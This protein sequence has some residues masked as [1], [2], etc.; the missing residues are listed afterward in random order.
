MLEVLFLGT[1]ASLPSRDRSPPCIA[2]RSNSDIVLLDCGEGSQRQMMISPM[3]FMKI[4]GIFITHM[5]GDHVFGLPGLLQTMGMSGRKDPLIVCGP[6]GFKDALAA[7]IH[8]CPGEILYALD[9]RELRDGDV[10]DMGS[11]E[12]YC[13][14]TMHNMPSLGY[15]LKEKDQKGRFDKEKAVKLGL[16]PSDYSRLQEGQS[17]EG[18]TPDM[19]I[20]PSRPGLRLVYSGDTL[21]CDRVREVSSDADLLIHEA[22]YCENETDL[23]S[24]YFHTTAKQAAEIA[25]DSRCKNLILVHI[26]N[27]YDDRS[28]VETEARGTFP[29]SYVADDLQM[30]MLTKEGLRSV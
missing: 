17:V 25:R 22:T 14:E 12:V 19:V 8:F 9:I 28:I 7:M 15:S 18:V 1:G 6:E 2:V 20:G 30:Y 21:P 13:F 10:V 5:H 27:R 29:S 3:S 24:K 11:T 16:R 23:A 26:S 4:K